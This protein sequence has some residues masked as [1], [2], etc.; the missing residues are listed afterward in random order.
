MGVTRRAIEKPDAIHSDRKQ[1]GTEIYYKKRTKSD[2]LRIVV[3]FDGNNG[4]VRTVFKC[5]SPKKGEVQIWP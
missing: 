3:E 5:D 2:Y 1:S 4:E